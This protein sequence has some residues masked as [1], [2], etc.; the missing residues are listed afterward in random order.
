MSSVLENLF[1]KDYEI[2]KKKD[3]EFRKKVKNKEQFY[4]DIL[5]KYTP[6]D[7]WVRIEDKNIINDILLQMKID[8]YKQMNIILEVVNRYF[9]WYLNE[10]DGGITTIG[11]SKKK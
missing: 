5:N 4:I 11:L 2:N 1:G 9:G 10:T 7:D 8:T 3:E 6:N